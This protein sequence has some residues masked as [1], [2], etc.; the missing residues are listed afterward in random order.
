MTEVEEKKGGP[1]THERWHVVEYKNADGTTGNKW[2]R[3]SVLWHN[4]EK[5]TFFEKPHYSPAP[6]NPG[7]TVIRPYTKNPT[8]SVESKEDE[9]PY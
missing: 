1:P 4:P 6:D 8:E 7:N 9:I 3:L 2:T 5:D